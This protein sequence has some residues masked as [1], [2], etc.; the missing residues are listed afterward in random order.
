M[1]IRMMQDDEAVVTMVDSNLQREQITPSEKERTAGSYWCNGGNPVYAITFAG[2]QDQE[3]KWGWKAYR[4]LSGRNPWRDKT[5]GS[6]Q[7]S[8]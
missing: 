2:N 6:R 5:E 8:F 3:I 4:K 1:I 7:S